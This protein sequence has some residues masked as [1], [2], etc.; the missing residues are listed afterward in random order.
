MKRSAFILSAV[1]LSASVGFTAAACEYHSGYGSSPFQSRWSNYTAEQTPVDEEDSSY[2]EEQF[3]TVAKKPVK[4]KP[5]FSKAASRA[6]DI[7]KL[8]VERTAKAEAKT[9]AA[10]VT[11]QASR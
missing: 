10:T 6:S 2:R 4:K 8:R 11:E 9:D 3:K 5:V 7:A 1:L